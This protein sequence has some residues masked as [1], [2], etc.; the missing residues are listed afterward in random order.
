MFDLLSGAS[1]IADLPNKGE[2][3]TTVGKKKS[4][5]ILMARKR[6]EI[7]LY[8]IPRRHI[9]SEILVLHTSYDIIPIFKWQIRKTQAA[10][11]QSVLPLCIAR[12]WSRSS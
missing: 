1:A 10:T 8:S 9:Q 7:K 6:E 4:I 11:G 2:G 12:S 5:F 3:L